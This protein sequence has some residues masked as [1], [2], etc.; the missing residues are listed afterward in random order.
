[1]LLQ[2]SGDQDSHQL[3]GLIPD[4]VPAGTILEILVV[5]V[6]FFLPSYVLLARLHFFPAVLRPTLRKV[7]LASSQI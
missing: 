6:I 7:K 2:A 5:P 1:M 3:P 4:L